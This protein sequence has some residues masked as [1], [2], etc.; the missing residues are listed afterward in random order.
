MKDYAKL[1]KYIWKLQKVY[2]EKAKEISEKGTLNGEILNPEVAD[3]ERKM[4]IIRLRVL[5][6]LTD[7]VDNVIDKDEEGE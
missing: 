1:L 5:D 7:Y 3:E 6:D 4:Y 2:Q